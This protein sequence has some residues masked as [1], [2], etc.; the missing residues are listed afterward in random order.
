[1]CCAAVAALAVDDHRGGVQEPRDAR[2]SRDPERH[3]RSVIVVQRVLVD[4]ADVD[5]EADLGSQMNNGVAAGRRRCEPIMIGD[6]IPSVDD[7]IEDTARRARPPRV[8]HEL[9]GRQNRHRR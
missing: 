3:R 2:F 6:V 9:L 8:D 1:M 4:V 5:P 7:P